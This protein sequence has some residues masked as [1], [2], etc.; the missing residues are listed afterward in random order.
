MEQ[1]PITPEEGQVLVTHVIGVDRIEVHDAASGE[2]LADVHLGNKA[3]KAEAAIGMLSEA[4]LTL[5]PGE[6]TL[7]EIGL[8]TAVHENSAYYQGKTLSKF[9][10][11]Q[12]FG[13]STPDNAG[14]TDTRLR[15]GALA[16][17]ARRATPEELDAHKHSRHQEREAAYEQEKERVLAAES[18]KINLLDYDHAY[19]TVDGH[20]FYLQTSL[21]DSILATRVLQAIAGLGY[22]EIGMPP[23]S[24]DIARGVWRLMPLA[25]R[26]L[27]LG[28]ERQLF[29]APSVIEPRVNKI[30][31]S[32][33]TN[34]L[35]I[36]RR[37]HSFNRYVVKTLDI[38]VK[39]Q[40]SPPETPYGE[41][42]VPIFP[43]GTPLELV[44]KEP[45]V[46]F[47]DT[48]AALA[49]RAL[50]NTWET[51]GFRL[52]H[53]EALNILD[54]VAGRTGKAALRHAL[55]ESGS[56]MHFEDVLARIYVRLRTSLGDDAYYSARRN[57]VIGGNDFSKRLRRGQSPHRPKVTT[58]WR[59]G[60]SS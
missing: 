40:P 33:L 42:V 7:H 50:Q 54:L 47:T 35:G 21:P 14:R 6:Y 34:L 41:E 55:K 53:E 3:N 12:A 2:Q 31:D 39:P 5:G 43:P 58:R 22:R 13:F 27:L 10:P 16:I 15:F 59:V 24:L 1:Q 26:R 48:E 52:D 8:R 60:Y 45:P 4:Y 57:R 28:G 19:I 44:R 9:L 11:E 25:E 29:G 20:N 23:R 56:S 32:G 30:L 17:A 49:Q 36:T 38:D 37:H 18:E 51:G 46:Q